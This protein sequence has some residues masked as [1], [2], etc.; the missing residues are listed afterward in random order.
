[1]PLG[2]RLKL[3]RLHIKSEYFLIW[4]IKRK[5]PHQQIEC[6]RMFLFFSL[7]FPQVQ[8]Y[9]INFITYYCTHY[10][11]HPLCKCADKK[12]L[13]RSDLSQRTTLLPTDVRFGV[14]PLAFSIPFLSPAM[15]LVTD[16]KNNC[17]WLSSL[18]LCGPT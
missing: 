15:R 7:L 8:F 1:M 18:P 14:S 11:F 5:S 17:S 16:I 10:S 4:N 9:L 13:H 6:L 12:V 2:Q 3:A